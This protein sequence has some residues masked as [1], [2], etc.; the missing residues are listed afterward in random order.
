[1]SSSFPLVQVR[2]RC[3]NQEMICML[4]SRFL[5]IPILNNLSG[6]YLAD[7]NR[8]ARAPH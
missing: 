7:T 4:V 8:L 1:M 3:A 2:L 5:K 6:N